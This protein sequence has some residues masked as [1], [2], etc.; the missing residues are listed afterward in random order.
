MVGRRPHPADPRDEHIHETYKAPQSVP[1]IGNQEDRI[2]NTGNIS[3]DGGPSESSK[4]NGVLK[5]HPGSQGPTYNTGHVPMPMTEVN[6][7]S[8]LW[9]QVFPCYSVICGFIFN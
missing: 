5:V 9:K 4:F 1:S 7:P 2:R 6:N 8:N 3:V